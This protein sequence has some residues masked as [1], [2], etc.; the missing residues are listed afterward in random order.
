MKVWTA[1]IVDEPENAPTLLLATTEAK[2]LEAVKTELNWLAGV[3]DCTELDDIAELYQEH[4]EDKGESYAGL[5]TGED[6]VL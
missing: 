1:M 5:F 3:A 6:E 4:C 2:L